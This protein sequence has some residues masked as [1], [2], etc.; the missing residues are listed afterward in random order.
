MDQASLPPPPSRAETERCYRHPDV[1]TGVHC[2]RCGN[3]ICTACMIPAP[4]G[5]QCP[6]CV[7]QARREFR[8]GPGRQIA[9]AEVKGVSVT[10]ILL[11]AIAGMYLVE[12]VA[13]GAGSLLSGPGSRR[14]LQ[15]GGQ[16]AL[17]PSPE[18]PIGVATGQYWRLFTAMFLH[19]GLIHAGLNAW[20]LFVVGTALE[21]DIGRARFA[22]LYL[23]AG[24]FASAASFAL[25]DLDITRTA[26]GVGVAPAVSVGAS[27]AIFGLFGAFVAYNWRYRHRALASARLRQI[28]P[29]VFLNI[30]FSFSFPFI[31]WRAH[32]GGL[33]AGLVAGYAVADPARSASANR[34]AAIAGIA[35]VLVA[36][37]ALTAYGVMRIRDLVPEA[38]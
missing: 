29:W 31:D 3:P 5:H 21:H 25:I 24:L 8:K 15:L 34:L 2:T 33:V 19:G 1:E 13:G 16:I 26:A 14:L 23:V 32:M 27:G 9:I 38:F 20:V 36:A 10:K 37:V 28:L 4:V 17:A 6:D 35:G 22:G 30:V 12:V 11:V 18:G 7:A